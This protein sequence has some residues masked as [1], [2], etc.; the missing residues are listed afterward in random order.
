MQ[1]MSVADAYT[2]IEGMSPGVWVA[3]SMDRSKVV[4][5]GP[6]AQAVMRDA[7]EQGEPHPL[8]MKVPQHASAMFL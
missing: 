8:I 5:Y 7:M 2:L 6:D 4:A 3:I 1:T